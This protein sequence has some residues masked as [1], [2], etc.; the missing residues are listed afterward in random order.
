MISIGVF[1]SG[2]GGKALANTLEKAFPSAKLTVVDDKKHAPYG[3]KT[4]TEIK[5]LTA[6]AIQPLLDEDVVVIACNTA[7]AYAIDELRE[8]H[9]DVKFVGIEPMLKQAAASSKSLVIAVC[10]T[11]ATLQSPRYRHLKAEY[12]HGIEIIEPDCSDWAS[13]IEA[14]EV[15]HE[16]IQQIVETVCAKGADVIVLGCT[17]YHWIKEDIERLAANRALVFEPSKAIAA[18]VA[19]IL[20]VELTP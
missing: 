18:R 15:N 7:T 14:N 1:D 17:H 11:P 3:T 9:P 5:R 16:H 13:M 10:A 12:G 20:K 19:S 6:Q 8:Q 2:I 4:P